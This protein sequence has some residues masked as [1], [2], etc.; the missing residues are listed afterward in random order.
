MNSTLTLSSFQNA[1]VAALAKTDYTHAELEAIRQLLRD[2]ET[3]R[4]VRYSSGS[5]S[6]VTPLHTPA[7]QPFFCV[8]SG[9]SGLLINGWDR[10]SILQGVGEMCANEDPA[11][12]EG[13]HIDA[14]AHRRGLLA[15]VI[16]HLRYEHRF[17][18]IIANR[19]SGVD[20]G[21]RPH[22]RYNPAA[23]FELA[24][25]WGHAQN[26]ALGSINFFLF[27]LLNR[28]HLDW[29][30]PSERAL[31]QR[32]ACL[33]HAFFW[34]VHVWE[35]WELGAWEDCKAEHA[36]SIAVVLA[37][38]QEQL[39]F[40]KAG[41]WFMNYGVS[42]DLLRLDG[43]G[44]QELIDNCT[45]KLREILPNEFIRGDGG[46]RQT[47]A[48]L[49]NGLF[50]AAMAGRPLIDDATTLQ[51]IDRI[52]TML[53][54]HIGTARYPHDTWQGR[55]VYDGTASLVF[56]R[57]G[58]EENLRIDIPWYQDVRFDGHDLRP[59]APAAQWTHVSPMISCIFGEMYQRTGNDE[60]RQRQL[61]HFNRGLA[62]VND[63]FHM[64]EA[65]IA[66]SDGQGGWN[67]RSDA[68]ESLAWS[69][70]M[71]L[72]SF[73]SLKRSI[74]CKTKSEAIAVAA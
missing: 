43:G 45:N 21:T 12:G 52:E 24:D 41:N 14:D 17:L 36:S 13:L 32:M 35:D 33:L 56:D 8:E 40:M 27:H 26:D 23:L 53:M 47:D 11:L 22:I 72:T 50:L 25:P 30:N 5:A 18:D 9:L 65:Y 46:T 3:L 31:Y 66:F 44:V 51:V 64:P 59:T 74:D 4:L 19:K 62:G 54:G 38:L 48:A 70:A 10:D 69:Q 28:K 58:K 2:H 42:H 71:L 67:W 61:F 20:L 39:K 29:S 49:V 34:K 55:L 73:A 68:N 1:E 60:Y 15:S 7:H 16:F 6:A 37:G 57:I 63:R